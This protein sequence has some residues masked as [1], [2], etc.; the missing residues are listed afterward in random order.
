M[1]WRNI[2]G[3]RLWKRNNNFSNRLRNK[4]KNMKLSH[5]RAWLFGVCLPQKA[6]MLVMWRHESWFVYSRTLS[7]PISTVNPESHIFLWQNKSQEA[8]AKRYWRELKRLFENMKLL[9]LATWQ[10]LFHLLLPVKINFDNFHVC[11]SNM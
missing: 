8:D 9:A 2:R 7:H 4:C 6:A 10:G 5:R 1:W 11:I 3:K